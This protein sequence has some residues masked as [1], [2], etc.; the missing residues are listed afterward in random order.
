MIKA[1]GTKIQ[2]PIT[3]LLLVALMLGLSTAALAQSRTAIEVASLGPQVGDLVPNFR[4]IDQNGT[5]QTLES[6][7][8]P[9]GTM[10]LFHR[11]ADW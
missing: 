8:G 4:L 2:K 9:N 3:S 1:M 5:P 10:L 11:S 7:A 6:I